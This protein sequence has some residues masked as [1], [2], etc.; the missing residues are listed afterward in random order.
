MLIMGLKK[1]FSTSRTSAKKSIV[2][3]YS[4][5]ILDNYFNTVLLLVCILRP[6]CTEGLVISHS[7]QR[8]QKL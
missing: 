2:V 6:E 8:F 1:F 7:T 3:S 5:A 4:V